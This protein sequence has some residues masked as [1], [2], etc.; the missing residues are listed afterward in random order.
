[1]GDLH[2]QMG[3]YGH[4][5]VKFF[6]DDATGLRG[7]IGIH[8]TTL[9]PAAGGTRRYAFESEEEA[10]EDV[11]RL[12]QAMTYKYAISGINMGGGKGVIWVEDDDHD[13]EDLYRS[14]GRIVDSFEGRFVTGGDV[15]TD[16][17]EMRWIGMETDYIIGLPE[18]F[19][20]P[21]GF[22][23][24]GL[25]VLRAM[26]ACCDLAYDGDR[27]L[28]DLHVAVQGAGDMGA[29]L[30]K[31]LTDHGV[32]VT[33]ADVDEAQVDYME[34]EYGVGSVDPEDVYDVDCDVFAPC[35]LGM[36]LNDD[37]IPRLECDIVC[38][39]AN[40]Q[41]DDVE[42]HDEMLREAGILYAP[43]YLANSG[44]TIDDTDLLRK[45]G[46]KHDR[47]RA[48]I[49]DIYD[50]MVTIGERAEREDRPTQTIADEIAEERIEAIQQSRSKVY[51]RRQPDW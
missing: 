3:R 10:L 40:N 38:G 37:T 23:G 30:I 41:L 46:Y 7:I 44:R 32:Q 26:E 15:G 45:G 48:M 1:M 13:S 17:K 2:Q 36:I 24:G 8:D 18:Q 6:R 16:A 19:D 33:L 22:H 5:E 11:L 43:D 51:E 49:D 20:H 4:N 29:S 27:N 35:A 28:S 39:A 21:E 14:Y 50:R 25:G 31:Y 34:D 47:A 9:G 42:R 12:S